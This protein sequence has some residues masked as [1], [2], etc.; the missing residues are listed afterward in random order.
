MARPPGSLL[1]APLDKYADAAITNFEHVE[2]LR[3]A[4][5]NEFGSTVEI[6]TAFGGK[7]KY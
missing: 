5:L 2:M 1:Q 7:A 6:I 3:L 4:P